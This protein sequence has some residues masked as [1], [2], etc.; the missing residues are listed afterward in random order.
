MLFILGILLDQSL[1]YG[2][3]YSALADLF[4]ELVVANRLS[5]AETLIKKVSHF[6]LSNVLHLIVKLRYF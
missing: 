2:H 5:E 3:S 1:K 4:V 6:S